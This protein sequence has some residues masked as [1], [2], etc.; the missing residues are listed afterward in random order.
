[1]LKNK[2]STSK[3]IVIVFVLLVVSLISAFSKEYSLT[4]M[5]ES[6]YIY[7]DG[8]VHVTENISYH[9]SG[10]FHWV[11]RDI[12]LKDIKIKNIK[13]MCEGAYCKPETEFIRNRVKIKANLYPN[14]KSSTNEI[15]NTNVKFQIDYDLSRV[16]KVYDDV[17]EFHYKPWGDEWDKKLGS[18]HT[19]IY[20]PEGEGNVSYWFHSVTE[21]NAIYNPAGKYL[22]VR[23]S[24][25]PAHNYFEIRLV[26]PE[27]WFDG[28]NENIRYISEDAMP[29]ILEIEHDYEN[30]KRILSM[31]SVLIPLIFI[32]AAV[33]I[34]F[35]VYYK[36]GR[37]PRKDYEGIYEREIPY[38][39]PPAVVNAVMR[40]DTG[41]PTIEAFTSTIM[42]L[43][44]RGYLNISTKKINAKKLLLFDKTK[45][46]LIIEFTDKAI[47][48]ISETGPEKNVLFLLYEKPKIIVNKKDIK[49]NKRIGKTVKGIK[50][51]EYYSLIF[52]FGFSREKGGKHRVSFNTLEK[53]LKKEFV[54]KWFFEFYKDWNI[55]VEKH[56]NINKIFLPKGDI[57]L[58]TYGLTAIAAI[59]FILAALSYVFD[60]RVI[61]MPDILGIF[62]CIILLLFK[63]KRSGEWAIIVA[64]SA[65]VIFG[66]M[67]PV[68][69]ILTFPVLISLIILFASA[70]ISLLLP[71][72]I[73][74]RWTP[75]GRTYYEKWEAFG[76]FLKDF[77][78][79][80]RYPPK[81]I[82][83]WEH[84]IV[85]ATALGIADKVIKNMQLII[86][87]EEVESLGIYAYLAVALSFN[88][89]FNSVISTASSGG[90]GGVGGGAGGGGGGAG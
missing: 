25:I 20:L 24:S 76:N 26:M 74:G 36:H 42:D 83:L 89:Y 47:D 87:K 51:F 1:M 72:K 35:L 19:K 43:A 73:G 61:G 41:K 38:D 70:A 85:Y 7:P 80:E 13:V 32:P 6:I 84:F 63:D 17:S 58:K 44:R 65:L 56:I 5:D 28:S 34:P 88:H 2:R 37:E 8:T 31:L 64:A 62:V 77:S 75:Y 68:F 69:Y 21:E 45:D 82:V 53:E 55:L 39:D 33:L 78:Q 86:Q 9:F 57:Y 59:I 10:C 67:P 3:W 46:D 14:E 52:L 11:E 54:N 60:I 49:I 16:I 18:L 81:S 66:L 79:M 50:N 29:E 4:S 30:K 48:V 90:V 40:E 15:C 12:P 22:D 71:D 27:D 23:T